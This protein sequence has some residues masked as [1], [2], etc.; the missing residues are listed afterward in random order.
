MSPTETGRPGLVA[1]ANYL[2]II[3]HPSRLAIALLLFDGPCS[4]SEIESAL[5]LRQPN[6]SQHLGVLRDANILTASRQAKSVTYT[7]CDGPPR[8]LVRGIAS[9]VNAPAT[10]IAPD[11]RAPLAAPPSATKSAANEPDDA[12][13]FAQVIAHR[14]DG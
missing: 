11:T 7:L 14:R 12:L 9:S 6:L 8:E 2:R 3:S 10:P 4:V 13:M 5:G 1:V